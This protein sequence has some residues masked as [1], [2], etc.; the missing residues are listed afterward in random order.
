MQ[1]LW[2]VG[3][4]RRARLVRSMVGV[5]IMVAGLLLAFGA[6]ASGHEITGI[7]VNCSEV[8]VHWSGFPEAGVSVHIVA[9]VGGVGST[10]TDVT[11]DHNSTQTQLNITS[12]TSQLNGASGTV[13]VDVTWTFEGP[14]HVHESKTVTCGNMSTTTTT[15]QSSGTTIAA[16]T[17]TTAPAPTTTMPESSSTTSTTENVGASSSTSSTTVH[18]GGEQTTP[19][20]TINVSPAE[21][22][23]SGGTVSA[24]GASSGSLPF[25]GT[26]PWLIVVGFFLCAAGATL[27][28]APRL[29]ARRS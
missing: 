22:S 3:A 20:T 27:V 17:T 4:G 21:L 29:R 9:A 19:T 23:N 2:R 8:T 18:V 28:V 12:L 1:E 15:V 11:V 26:N 16:S 25:T 10:S 14:Q 6:P 13:D 7:D 24:T 5:V